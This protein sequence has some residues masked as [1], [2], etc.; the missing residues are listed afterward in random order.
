MVCGLISLLP[1]SPPATAELPVGIRPQHA[2]IGMDVALR[3]CDTHIDQLCTIL[4]QGFQHMKAANS[5]RLV[6]TGG[7]AMTITLVTRTP[8]LSLSLSHALFL[9]HNHPVIADDGR[10][11]VKVQMQRLISL[12]DFRFEFCFWFPSSVKVLSLSLNVQSYESN[13]CI[14]SFLFFVSLYSS[15]LAHESVISSV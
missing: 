7:I 11:S 4:G 14:Y 2:G 10:L 6:V 15:S 5:K 3:M 8:L 1:I 12:S 9:S 13:C